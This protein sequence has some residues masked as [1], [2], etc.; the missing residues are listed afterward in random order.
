VEEALMRFDNDG[1]TRIAPQVFFGYDRDRI[2]AAVYVMQ[3]LFLE[4]D[5]RR[6]KLSTARKS[7]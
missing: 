6:S 3:L 4:V 5:V 7:N 2:C 1:K